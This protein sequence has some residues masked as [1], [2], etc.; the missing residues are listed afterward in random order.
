MR[1]RPPGRLLPHPINQKRV[2]TIRKLL[3]QGMTQ[4]LIAERV[5]LTPQGVG[6]LIKRWIKKP[7]FKGAGQ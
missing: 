5:G 7:R 1:G 2:E 4:R 3:A 6:Y